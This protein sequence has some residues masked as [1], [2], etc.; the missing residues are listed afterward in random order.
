MRRMRPAPLP[1]GIARYPKETEIMNTS[2]DSQA[3]KLGAI[4]IVLAVVL[5]TL[6]E[7]ALGALPAASAL[8]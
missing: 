6:T 3:W 7:F 5:P 4:A 1:A 2:P 8:A